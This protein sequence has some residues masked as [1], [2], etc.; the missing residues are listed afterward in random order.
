MTLSILKIWKTEIQ[1]SK[2]KFCDCGF[3]YF[4]VYLYLFCVL[5]SPESV[6]SYMAE[7][8]SVPSISPRSCLTTSLWLAWGLFLGRLFR[9]AWHCVHLSAV[10]RWVQ[11]LQ[12][13]GSSGC[14]EFMCRSLKFME[15]PFRAAFGNREKKVPL[16]K[17]FVLVYGQ[18]H[19]Y[20]GRHQEKDILLSVSTII[21]PLIYAHSLSNI[22][23]IW[24]RKYN[25]LW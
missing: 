12:A 4:Y 25:V 14:V 2:V 19:I 9:S 24:V 23:H 16:E 1:N 13:A 10:L 17:L 11:F 6:A 21:H 7:D 3:T 15:L 5:Y 18:V 22:L 20:L 8:K